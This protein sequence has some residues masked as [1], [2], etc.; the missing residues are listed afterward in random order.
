M[1]SSRK[2]PYFFNIASKESVWDP[3]AGLTQEQISQLPGAKEYLSA[4]G[5]KS[6]GKAD[7]VRA[8]HLLVKHRDSRRPSS[9]KEVPQFRN[10]RRNISLIYGSS[11]EYHSQQGRSY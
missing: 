1:S 11:V 4:S 2:V 7:Q 9:W 10:P 3:P 8:S 6:G 5:P